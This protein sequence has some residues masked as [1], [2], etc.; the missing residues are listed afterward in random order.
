MPAGAFGDAAII[1]VR[2]E[3]V[4]EEVVCLVVSGWWRGKFRCKKS[5]KRGD[6]T[7]TGELGVGG[8]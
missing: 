6:D 1:K 7:C 3:R 5:E 8:A 4:N 2:L